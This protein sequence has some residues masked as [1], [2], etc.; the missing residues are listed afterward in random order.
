MSADYFLFDL[1]GTLIDSIPDMTTAVNLLR[2]ELGLPALKSDQVRGFV[3]DG[4]GLLVQRALPAELFSPERRR[5]YMEIYAAHLT[6]ET[7]AYPGI[8]HFLQLHEDKPMAVVTNKPQPLAETIV[9]R[10][11]LSTFFRAVIGAEG[12]LSKKPHPAMVV[13]AMQLLDGRPERAV[14]FGDHH[15]DL[16]AA[17]AA[18]VK[19]CFCAWGL[20][21]EDG[22]VAD[23][24]ATTPA[25]LPGIFPGSHR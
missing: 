25:E 21:H 20:G 9:S 3:G 10:L 24:R 13:H 22:L 5:R 1:D 18:G 12:S 6:D 7:R 19:S 2:D 8:M 23:Y 17:M 15:V 4:V 16:R 11:G 14:L